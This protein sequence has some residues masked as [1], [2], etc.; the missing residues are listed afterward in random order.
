MKNVV[1]SLKSFKL[2]HDDYSFLEV[3]CLN[4]S[5]CELVIHY[6]FINDYERVLNFFFSDNPN[7]FASAIGY[8]D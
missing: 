3:Y 2:A 4:G 1:N 8:Q 5:L 7:A 6:K